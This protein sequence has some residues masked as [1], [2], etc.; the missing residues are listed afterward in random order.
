VKATSV[1]TM[2]RATL[3]SVGPDTTCSH[4]SGA[5]APAS[6]QYQALEHQPPRD[7]TKFSPPLRSPDNLGVPEIHELGSFVEVTD[8]E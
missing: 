1:L 2:T 7:P 5:R 6:I 4:Y 3:T 8:T